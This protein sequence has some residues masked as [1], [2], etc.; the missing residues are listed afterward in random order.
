MTYFV[1]DAREHALYDPTVFM[2]SP[3]GA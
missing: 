1:V 3:I 2:S